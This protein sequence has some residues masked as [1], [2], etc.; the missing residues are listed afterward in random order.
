ML[1]YELTRSDGSLCP[2]AGMQRVLTAG[3]QFI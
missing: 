3:T 1:V 2:E